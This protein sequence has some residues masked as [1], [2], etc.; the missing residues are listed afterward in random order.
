MVWLRARDVLAG[1]DAVK[2]A[3]ERYLSKL[4][5]QT[6]DEYLAYKSRAS[7]FNATA[8]TADGYVGLI[9]RREP[10]VKCGPRS[11]ERGVSANDKAMTEFAADVDLLGNSLEAYAK[12][13]VSEV[14]GVGRAG[15]LVDW[16]EN[17]EKRAYSVMYHAENIL[18][19]RMERVG[20][21][22]VVTLVVLHEEI[23]VA[24]GEELAGDDFESPTVEQ[25]RVLKLVWGESAAVPVLTENG[26]RITSWC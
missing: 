17:G 6:P 15:T 5:S 24:G 7:F 14:I 9:F 8:R 21:R 19:W 3:G 26:S 23:S 22:N 18:N 16:E 11:S 2:S 25:I 13:V 20:G 12:N 1:E 10:T 4:V